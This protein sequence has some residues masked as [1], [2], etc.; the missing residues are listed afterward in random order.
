MTKLY[1]KARTVGVLP[2]Y[3]ADPIPVGKIPDGGTQVRKSDVADNVTKVLHTVTAGKTLYLSFFTLRAVRN[4]DNYGY[5]AVR[6]TS[7]V[8]AYYIACVDSYT[9]TPGNSI[10]GT[11]LPPLEI[12]AGWDIILHSPAVGMI[13]N[14]F[15]H[16]YE[17]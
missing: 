12:T 10:T 3:D 9:S 6:N 5:L 15:I 17:A 7:D 8:I 11:L 4:V 13:I 14:G 16:G 1:D 2:F